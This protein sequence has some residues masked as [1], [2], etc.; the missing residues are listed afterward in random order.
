[1]YSYL[2]FASVYMCAYTYSGISIDIYS[3]ELLSVFIT[4]FFG[5]ALG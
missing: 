4:V 3:A 5:S 1:M 2:Y